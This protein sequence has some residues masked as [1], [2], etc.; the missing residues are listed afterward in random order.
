MNEYFNFRLPDFNALHG[1]DWQDFL[2][3][4]ED[5]V[6]DLYDKTYELYYL[7]DINRMS[8]RVVNINL[9]VLGVAYEPSDSPD[10]K[11]IKLRNLA[12]ESVNKGMDVVYLD[13]AEAIVGIRGTIKGG[14]DI[15]VY[16][17]GVSRW[18]GT[19]TWQSYYIRWTIGGNQFIIYIDVKTL[20]NGELDQIQSLFQHEYLLPAFYQ[21]YLIDSS[22]NVLRTI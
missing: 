16:R 20:D 4:E 11:R 19:P 2:D 10:T 9:D 14:Q 21:I 3:I 13:I 22:F 15:G 18:K 8:N 7:N 1:N 6:D 5:Y 17:W 12:N